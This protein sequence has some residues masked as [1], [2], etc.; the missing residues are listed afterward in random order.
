M[1]KK[2]KSIPVIKTRR[3]FFRN[4]FHYLT[5]LITNFRVKDSARALSL[6]SQTKI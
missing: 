4:R 5:Q 3:N 2:K 6:R 1:S